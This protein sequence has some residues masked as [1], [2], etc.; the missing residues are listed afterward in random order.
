MIRVCMIVYNYYRSDARVRR[1]AEALAARGDHVDCICLSEPDMPHVLRGVHLHQPP[2]LLGHH[3]GR[4]SLM[5]LWHYGLFFWWAVWAVT[6]LH[7]RHRYHVVHVHN[8]PDFLVFAAL[9]PRLTGARLVLDG[10]DLMTKLYAAKFG[11]SEKHWLIKLIRWQTLLSARFAHHVLCVHESHRDE[12]I[13]LGIP[14]H[15]ISVVLNAADDRFFTPP[16]SVKTAESD[17]FDLVYHG[18][19]ADRF[20]LAVPVRAVAQLRSQIP[21]LKFYILG[22]GDGL[23]GLEQLIQELQLSA[24]VCCSKRFL[25]LEEL[26]PLLSKMQVGLVPYQPNG[27]TR[28]ILPVKLLEYVALGVPAIAV[29]NPVIT[30]YFDDSMVRFIESN[31]VEEFVAAILEL[32][33][34]PQKRLVLSQNAKRFYEKHSWHQYRRDYLQLVDRLSRR[35]GK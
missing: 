10:H 22:D 21:N 12:L 33:Q 30:C 2:L 20:G 11:V 34:E 19:I 25:P 29:R 7:L 15:K 8:M 27:F 4:S 1:V 24:V 13:A 23:S 17:S 16:D 3:R 26:P 14:P 31:S 32:Y 5:Y 35:E 28:L 18:T 6:K 9:I